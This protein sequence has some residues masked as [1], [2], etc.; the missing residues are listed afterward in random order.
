MRVYRT[1]CDH[2]NL[3]VYIDFFN[4]YSTISYTCLTNSSHS[5]QSEFFFLSWF[6]SFTQYVTLF[7]Y[8]L[9]TDL[10]IGKNQ[11]KDLYK[12]QW[13][14]KEKYLICKGKQTC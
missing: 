8:F 5:N 6:H 1:E 7:V 11:S 14:T 2:S 10:G 4:T 12:D 3:N 13:D 9:D